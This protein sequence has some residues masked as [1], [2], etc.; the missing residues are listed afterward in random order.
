VHR[1]ATGEVERVELAADEAAAPHPVRD[2]DVDQREPA[3]REE[4]QPP[5]FMRSDT[6]PLIS[7]TVM[8]ANIIWKTMTAYVGMPVLPPRKSHSSVIVRCRCRST[9]RSCR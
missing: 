9:A 3:E 5:N 6:R 4:T 1:G 2:R 7:A 8:I